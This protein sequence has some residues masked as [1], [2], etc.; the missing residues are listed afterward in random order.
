[1]RREF[2]IILVLVWGMMAQATIVDVTIEP[3][4]PMETDII[5]IFVSGE[6]TCSVSVTDSFLIIE[7]SS[8]ELDIYLNVGMMP[9]VTPWIHT[10]EIGYLSS[11][12]Y[13]LTVNSV[14]DDIFPDPDNY[15]T[16]FEVIPEPATVLLFGIG[17]LV[18]WRRRG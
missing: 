14:Y 3:E 18:L 16:T 2:I 4:E 11:G 1:M 10:E 7:G 8:V 5:S 15:V 17:G 9:V 6:D 13:E 12:I